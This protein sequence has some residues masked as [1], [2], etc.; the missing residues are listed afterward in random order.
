[1]R[2]GLFGGTFDPIHIG[3]LRAASEVREGFDLDQIFFIP[4]ASPPHKTFGRV[5][6][7]ADRLKMVELSVSD[8]SGFTVLDVELKRSG[9]SYTIDTIYHLKK[10]Q[11]KNCEIFFILG[12]DAF[13][14]IDT[15]KSYQ[16]LLKQVAFIVITRPILDGKD[17]SSSWKMLE[18]F[19]KS[20]ISDDYKFCD[21]SFC[22]QHPKARPIYIFDVTSLDISATRIRELVNKGASIS[23]LVTEKVENYI[24]TRGLYL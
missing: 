24:K 17:L 5:T 1:M 2:I 20:K 6:D 16:E 15:W 7:A 8:H 12:L 19:L 14:E 11:S 21:S 4:A 22:F 3:H 9:P 10:S 18:D 13:L 23:F